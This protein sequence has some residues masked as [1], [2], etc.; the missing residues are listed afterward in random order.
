MGV[1]IS[2]VRVEILIV[3]GPQFRPSVDA[4]VAERV[5]VQ[6][7]GVPKLGGAG[8]GTIM[9]LAE[10]YFTGAGGQDPGLR[11]PSWGETGGIREI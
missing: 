5:Q 11:R 4:L 6:C 10:P 1:E 8:S 2:V 9:V 7:H 3:H